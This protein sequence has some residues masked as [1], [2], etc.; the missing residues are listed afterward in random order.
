MGIEDQP[1][2]WATPV[3]EPIQVKSKEKFLSSAIERKA[4]QLEK[5][6][7][8]NGP[9]ILSP[10]PQDTLLT[11]PA[12]VDW[13][14]VSGVNYLSW[15]KNQHIPT[16]CG[17]CWAQGTTSSLADRF[18]IAMNNEYQISLAVQVIINCDAGGSCEG[19]NAGPVFEFAEKKGIP[20]ETC[21]NYVSKDPESAECTDIQQCMTC[22]P[23]PGKVECSA[24]TPWRR[25]HAKE[26]GSVSGADNIKK[27][28]ATRGPIAC[29][30]HVTDG[31]EAYK[32]GIYQESGWFFFP[33]HIISLIGYG[34][35]DQ[36]QEYWIGRNSWGNYWGESGFFRIAMGGHNL[37][38]E[39]DC[40]WATR[41]RKYFLWK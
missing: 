34:V 13:R 16:Y 10:L 40:S 2:Y 15:N 20:D 26:Y 3:L 22:V 31:F 38:I 12:A 8:K 39:D 21:Q 17:S 19:G 18:H 25:Y 36:G 23:P 24:V 30:M 35:T 29:S 1:A 28:I 4:C 41:S 37:L 33:N 27:E 5:T 11:A 32:G 14:N 6:F 9:K 7:F